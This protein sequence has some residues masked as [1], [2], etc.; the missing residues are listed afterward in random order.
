MSRP[1]DTPAASE[2]SGPLRGLRVLEL[3]SI[4]PGPFAAMLLS[5]MGAE[6]VR[7]ERPGTGPTRTGTSLHRGRRRVTADLKDPAGRDLVLRLA[8]RPTR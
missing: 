8:R 1:S 4:G 5:D 3:A 6:V 7:V 2:R